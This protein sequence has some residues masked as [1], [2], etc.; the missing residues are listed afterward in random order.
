M[1]FI[2]GMI[3]GILALAADDPQ[4]RSAALAEGEA[5]LAAGSI[6][7]NHLHFRRDAIDA[8]LDAGDW[9]G[10]ELHSSAL[11]TYTREEPLPWSNFFVARGRALAACGRGRRDAA[12]AAELA[13]LMEEGKRLAFKLSLP[14]LELALAGAM[15]R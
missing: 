12:L 5:L 11:E 4:L 9:S 15:S 6:S 14:A 1:A 10:A 7:H 13:L 3:L 2:G 8:C